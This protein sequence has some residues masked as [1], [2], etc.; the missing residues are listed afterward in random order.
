MILTDPEFEGTSMKANP[1]PIDN[2]RADIIANG[3]NFRINIDDLLGLTTHQMIELH[4]TYQNFVVFL[5]ELARAF[6]VEEI[7]DETG[8]VVSVSL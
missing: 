6:G 4:N 7:N 3:P 2:I 8:N 5:D 1:F